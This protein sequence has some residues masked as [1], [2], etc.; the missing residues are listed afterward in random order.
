M[1]LQHFDVHPGLTKSISRP[2]CRS[3]SCCQKANDL[4][5]NPRH[6]LCSALQ[7]SNQRHACNCR[8]NL[9]RNPSSTSIRHSITSPTFITTTSSHPRCIASPSILTPMA[10]AQ[11]PRTSTSLTPMPTAYPHQ[12]TRSRPSQCHSPIGWFSKGPTLT[13][14]LNPSLPMGLS[15]NFKCC[16]TCL[17]NLLGAL[18]CNSPKG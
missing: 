3:L 16:Q 17:L 4:A 18:P 6:F 8:A 15:T 11:A 2:N 13:P 5:I 7:A 12:S 9:T 14:R 1:L 10:P